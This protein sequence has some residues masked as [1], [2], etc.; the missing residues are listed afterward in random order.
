[1]PAKECLVSVNLSK[2]LTARMLVITNITPA[3]MLVIEAVVEGSSINT[4]FKNLN[5]PILISHEAGDDVR[6]PGI[7]DAPG[8]SPDYGAEDERLPGLVAEKR[9]VFRGFLGKRPEKSRAFRQVEDSNHRKYHYAED[10]EK[11]LKDVGI[12]HRQEAAQHGVDYDHSASQKE[13]L[14]VSEFHDPPRSLRRTESYFKDLSRGDELRRNVGRVEKED[15]HDRGEAQHGASSLPE[16][17]FQE[18][19]NGQRVGAAGFAPE[20]RSEN[21]P[22]ENAPRGAAHHRPDE[23]ES[24]GVSHTGQTDQK[25]AGHVGGLGAYRRDPGAEAPAAE[26]EIPQGAV[27]PGAPGADRQE[28]DQIEEEDEDN[29]GSYLRGSAGPA[30]PSRPGAEES[31]RGALVRHGGGNPAPAQA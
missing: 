13:A 27:A 18:I 3:S 16:L 9:K 7:P 6:L 22:V 24:P 25:P 1:M 20:G 2:F 30:S 26:D 31:L 5:R 14:R 21:Q 19:G 4:E 28:D 10:H 11:P 17:G 15:D 8:E 12:A 29:H 23:G